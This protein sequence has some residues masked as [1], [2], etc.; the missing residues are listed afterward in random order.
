MASR[1]GWMPF[2][3]R[4]AQDMGF[5]PDLRGAAL[6]RNLLQAERIAVEA[7]FFSSPRV[8]SRFFQKPV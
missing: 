2:N 5:R 8:T 4:L 6:L 7:V 1:E 3:E